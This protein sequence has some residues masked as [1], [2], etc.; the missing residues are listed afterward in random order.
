M[1][2]GAWVVGLENDGLEK[3]GLEKDDELVQAGLR[4]GCPENKRLREGPTPDQAGV[5]CVNPRINPIPDSMASR[6]PE[7]VQRSS[8]RKSVPR[9]F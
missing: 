6:V 2:P 4:A 5:V 9:V 1:N 7:P 3:D 8:S